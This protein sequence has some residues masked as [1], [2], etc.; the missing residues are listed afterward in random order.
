MKLF[1]SLVILLYWIFNSQKSDFKNMAKHQIM[2]SH[3]KQVLRLNS[4]EY[5]PESVRVGNN[6]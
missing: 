6:H 1:S 5:I 2:Q 4:I 3:R